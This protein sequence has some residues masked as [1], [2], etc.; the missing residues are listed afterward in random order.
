MDAA[1]LNSLIMGDAV[2]R[3]TY[4]GTFANDNLPRSRDQYRSF[5]VNTDPV[6]LGG[7]HW[8][9]LFFN[10]KG[11]CIFFCSYGTSPTRNIRTFARN[12]SSRLRWNTNSLQHPLSSTCGLFCMYFLYHISRCLSIHSL[13]HLRWCENERLIQ[14]FAHQNLKLRNSSF[15]AL[16]NQS[17]RP[18]YK[19]H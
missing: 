7:T 17:C 18:L 10:R 11:V 5:I 12:N 3:S 8:Q 1:T 4:G 13:K 6:H 9:A 14:R 15:F 19:Y 2:I 16:T